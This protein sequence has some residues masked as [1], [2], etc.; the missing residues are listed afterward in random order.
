MLDQIKDHEPWFGIEQ[1]FYI[2]NKDGIPLDWNIFQPS[3]GIYVSFCEARKETIIISLE[4][5]NTFSNTFVH[6]H[7]S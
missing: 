6:F 3:I 5:Q 1:E 4:C 7:N 2:T